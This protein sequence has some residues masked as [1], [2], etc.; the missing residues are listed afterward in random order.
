V[1]QKDTVNEERRES[2]AVLAVRRRVTLE[3]LKMALIAVML[4]SATA[5]FMS[6]AWF[7]QN[8]DVE[9]EGNSVNMQTATPSLYIS[10]GSAIQMS[11]GQP[12]RAAL[13]NITS[14]VPTPLYPISTPDC[15]NWFYLSGWSLDANGAHQAGSD[16]FAAASLT[17]TEEQNNTG[18]AYATYTNA[19]ESASR[20]A[21]QRYTFCLYTTDGKYSDDS[22]AMDVYLQETDPVTVTGTNVSG[23]LYNSLRVA[24]KSGNTLMLMAPAAEDG[25]LKCISAAGSTTAGAVA[26]A[27]GIAN[28][29]APD[30]TT[31][32]C[33]ATTSGTVVEVYVWLEGTDA[34][35]IVTGSGADTTASLSVTVRFT[36]VKPAGVA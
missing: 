9:G 23:D 27:T 16:T 21:Y 2:A 29:T 28:F 36:G 30:G 11:N 18:A 7:A 15:T 6:R 25:G 34:Q 31:P 20:F 22:T 8:G 10:P 13:A 14:A 17:V 4:V 1:T 12:T 19:I 35:A 3:I 33:Q 26:A 24:V 32:V 5:A